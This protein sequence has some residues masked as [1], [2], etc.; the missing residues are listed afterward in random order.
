MVN[1]EKIEVDI[2]NQG[3]ITNSYLVY[4]EEKEAILIDPRI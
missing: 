3:H 4:D 1:I 2:A